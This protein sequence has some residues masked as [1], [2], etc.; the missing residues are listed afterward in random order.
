MKQ[1][2]EK[3]KKEF[4]K[5]Y[6]TSVLIAYPEYAESH[7]ILLTDIWNWH[8]Q[9]L[10]QFIDELIARLDGMKK[11]DPYSSNDFHKFAQEDG[12]VTLNSETIP[13]VMNNFEMMSANMQ[14]AENRDGYNRA[15]DEQISHLKKLKEELN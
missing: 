10:K 11:Q 13:K 2:I 7:M 6:N 12:A 14:G 1:L 3:Q 4:E 9:S 5:K 8:K 15:I